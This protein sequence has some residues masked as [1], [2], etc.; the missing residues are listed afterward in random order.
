MDEC[1]EGVWCGVRGGEGLCCR[2][3]VR[4][5]LQAYLVENLLY[6]AFNIREPF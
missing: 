2:L 1:G 5:C 6:F 4:H 3:F